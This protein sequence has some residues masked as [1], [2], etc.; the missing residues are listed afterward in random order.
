[1]DKMRK[2]S[3]KNKTIDQTLGINKEKKTLKEFSKE[4]KTIDQT[5]KNIKEKFKKNNG[6]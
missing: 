2:F 4:N 6:N 3:K 5:F 1:M